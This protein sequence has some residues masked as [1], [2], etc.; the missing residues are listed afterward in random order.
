MRRQREFDVVLRP[1]VETK[2]AVSKIRIH[3]DYHLGQVLFT[4]GLHHRL[5]G[6]AGRTLAERR[7]EYSALRDVASMLRSLDYAAL[8][9]L[10]T[11]IVRPSD[12]AWLAPFARAWSAWMGAAFVREYIATI[13]QSVLVPEETVATC[14]GSRRAAL[15]LVRVP[16]FDA[17]ELELGLLWV[18]VSRRASDGSES[19]GA[20]AADRRPG[21]AGL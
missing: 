8:S 20:G 11:G 21:A 5:R 7:F 15:R 19:R 14:R 10:R 2:M 9:A 6:R 13:G 18:G 12:V 1:L 16:L 3:G 4:G 17:V